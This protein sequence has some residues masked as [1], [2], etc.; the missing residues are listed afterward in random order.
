VHIPVA[1]RGR[2]L[3]IALGQYEDLEVVRELY[4]MGE[5]PDDLAIPEPEVVVDLG[6][7]IGLSL[8][9]FRLRYPHA[10]L[11]GVEPDPIAFNTLRLNTSGDPNIQILPVA[12]AAQDGMR[13]FFSSTMSV[14]SGFSRHTPFQRPVSV[15]AR[16]LDSLMDDLD[17]QGIDLLKIDVEGAEEEILASATR[18]TDVGAVVGELHAPALSVTMAEFYRRYLDGFAVDSVD[19]GPDRSTFV[20]RRRNGTSGDPRRS[21]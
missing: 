20:A 19:R 13:Q 5:Y 11:I 6:A 2:R 10:R 3:Q 15:F 16:S 8:L 7:N 4:L 14:V 12:A 1:R 18:L 9:D 21:D 17:L